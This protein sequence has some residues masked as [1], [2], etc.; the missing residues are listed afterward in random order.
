MG[1][2][3][4]GRRWVGVGWGVMTSFDG[5][6]WSKSLWPL[7]LW[8][9]VWT[10]AHYLAVGGMNRHGLALRSADGG[11]WRIGTTD[12]TYGEPGL[13]G[14]ASDRAGFLAVSETAILHSADGRRWIE[15][16]GDPAL[17]LDAV[18]ASASGAIA[19]GYQ[20]VLLLRDG[21]GHGFRSGVARSW[22]ST[23]STGSVMSCS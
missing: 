6:S 3:S 19:V 13:L 2:A 1:L 16:F 23:V 8:D 15:D 21:G 5:L 17:H 18:A 22:T 10:G 20:G 14:V 7:T 11:D 4:E 12:Q 9:I